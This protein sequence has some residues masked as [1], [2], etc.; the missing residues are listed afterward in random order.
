[1]EYRRKCNVCGKIYC[2]TS[3][4][5]SNNSMNAASATISAVGAIAS[6]FGGTRLDTYALNSQA[7]RYGSKI[8]KFE[9]CPNC[10]SINTV[11][12]SD[13]EWAEIQ[14]QSE[15]SGGIAIKAIEINTN[16]TVESLLKRAYLFLEDAEWQTAD[17]YFEKILDVEPENAQAYLGKLLAEFQMSS[18]SELQTCDKEFEESSN[19]QKA[20]RFADEKLS[21]KLKQYAFEHTYNMGISAKLAAQSETDYKTAAEYFSRIDGFRDADQLA[22]QCLNI[23]ENEPKYKQAI[24]LQE[25]DTEQSLEQAAAIY[26]TIA[27]YK[28]SAQNAKVCRK[29]IPILQEELRQKRMKE[30]RVAEEKRVAKAASINRIKKI[31]IFSGIAAVLVATITVVTTQIA[32]PMSRYNHAEELLAVGD[33]DRAIAIFMSLEDYKDAT[34]RALSAHYEKAEALLEDGQTIAAAMEFG[35][36]GDFSD[37]RQRSFTLW[38]NIVVRQTISTSNA[39]VD[40]H[41]VGLKTDGHVIAVGGNQ[42]GQC[43]VGGWIDI[44]EVSA[45][46]FYTVGL[47][48][49]G[50]VVAVGENDNGQCNV[51]DWTDIV[52][53]SADSLYTVGLKSD[54]TVMVT[55]YLGDPEY[56]CDISDTNT[57]NDIVAIST[58]F[59]QIVGL[60]SDGTVMMVGD[61][62]YGQC[63]VGDWENIVAIAVDYEYTIGLKSDGTVVATGRNQYGECDVGS[64]NDIVAVSAGSVTAG[65]KADGTVVTVGYED[66]VEC[67][68]SSW[69]NIVSISAGIHYVIGLKADGTMVATEYPFEI[70]DGQCNVGHWKGIRVE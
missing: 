22:E 59:S 2:Y 36:I 61:N 14:K 63:N 37:A 64:W 11:L 7:D 29:R 60:K 26:D 16:A 20:I 23:A 1:M 56:V 52:A 41:T 44:V 17:A 19:W 33:F 13:E 25:Q 47:K 21:A 45:G 43:D 8:I 68:V 9:Q 67:D 15:S 32:I 34:E 54:G 55:E 40:D 53:I 6:F 69:R 27:L 10:H 39:T 50:S 51:D 42:Y 3:D 46:D 30:E 58:A 57:W 35:K 49:D 18:I 28:D 38:E 5:L 48:S 62:K 24:A 66:D 4:D 65:L 31:A 70:Y 12:L